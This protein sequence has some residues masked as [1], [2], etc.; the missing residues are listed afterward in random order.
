MHRIITII[1]IALFSLS[2]SDKQKGKYEQF[3]K[4]YK[5]EAKA[6]LH[7]CFPFGPLPI[8]R[9][10]WINLELPE[11]LLDSNT[12]KVYEL[13]KLMPGE[14]FT[15]YLEID[16]LSYSDQL[17]SGTVTL[18]F[19]KNGKTVYKI[20]PNLSDFG[21]T[22]SDYGYRFYYMPHINGKFDSL[23]QYFVSNNNENWRIN[24]EYKNENYSD[25]I[26]SKISIEGGSCTTL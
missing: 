26:R 10:Y 22:T 13:G 3:I 7:S 2:C 6:V 11:F 12:K 1:T 20:N 18:E 8:N 21:Q 14:Q 19:L 23:S 25:S 5:G 17:L 15:T 24:F 9:Y 4:N 16:T